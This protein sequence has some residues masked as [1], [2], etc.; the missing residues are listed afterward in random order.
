MDPVAEMQDAKHKVWTDLSGKA[1]AYA[2]VVVA[3]AICYFANVLMK[4]HERD[5]NRGK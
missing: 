3:Y 1:I 2:I 4:M 5:V